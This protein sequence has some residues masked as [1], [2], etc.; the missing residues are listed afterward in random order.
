MF[1][2]KSEDAQN[3]TTELP[4]LSPKQKEEWIGWTFGLRDDMTRRIH[5]LYSPEFSEMDINEKKQAIDD[6]IISSDKV[7]G[8]YHEGSGYALQPDMAANLFMLYMGAN[9]ASDCAI[10]ASSDLC[11]YVI[12]VTDIKLKEGLHEENK[13]ELE[14]D[15][16]I[17]EERLEA[18][19]KIKN[20]FLDLQHTKIDF[21]LDSV[22]KAEYPFVYH[23]FKN[24]EFTAQDDR[25]KNVRLNEQKIF[26]NAIEVRMNEHGMKVDDSVHFDA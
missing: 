18:N 12:S 5:K 14:K 7:Y 8:C 16:S 3:T 1:S 2:N 9:R 25:S 20:A 21:V 24:A 17:A 13:F 10:S 23:L 4:T 19:E 22:K 26:L 11:N 6:T 15:K